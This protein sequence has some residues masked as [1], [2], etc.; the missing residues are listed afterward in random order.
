MT[1]L[2]KG[3]WTVQRNKYP[4]M[5]NVLVVL[6]GATADNA[7]A[8]ASQISGENPEWSV[9]CSNTDFVNVSVRNPDDPHAVPIF[10]G[11]I[12]DMGGALVA[13]TYFATNLDSD[14]K[15]VNEYV[16]EEDGSVWH[17]MR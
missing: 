9:S 14:R 8:V 16:V 12:L 2:P 15:W 11:S 17:R 1:A 3:V 10:E 13:G 4:S 5:S 7:L 6:D